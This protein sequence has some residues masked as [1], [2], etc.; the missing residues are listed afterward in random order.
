M[1]NEYKKSLIDYVTGLLNI[2]QQNPTEFDPN[3]LIGTNDIDYNAGPWSDVITALSGKNACIN[4]ILENEFSDI[5]ILYGGYQETSGTSKGFL[6]YVNEYDR[7]IKIRLLD[8]RGFLHLKFDESSNR[9]YGVVSNRAVYDSSGDNEAYFVYFNNLFLTVDDDVLP[10]QTYAYKIWNSDDDYFAVRDIVKHPENSWYLIFATNF[11][12]LSSPRV[13]ELQINVGEPNELKVW[14]IESVLQDTY[15]GYAFYG[16]YSGDTPHFKVII[17]NSNDYSFKLAINNGDNLNITNLN[18]DEAIEKPQTFFTKVD[19]ISIDENDIY[20]I[21]NASWEDNGTTKKQCVC[22]K[23][24]GTSIVT[25]YKTIIQ[26]Y[27]SEDNYPI[28]MMNIV[29]DFN[30]VYL[31]RYIWDNDIEVTFIHTVNITEYPIPIETDFI[32]LDRANTKVD[33]VNIYN[34][35]T[36]LRRNFNI[37]RFNSYAG[38][39]RENL[40]DPTKAVNGFSNQGGGIKQVIGYTGYPYSDYNVLVPRYANLY[41]LN[42]VCLF[43]RNFYNITRFE[44]ITTASVEVPASYLNNYPIS[45]EKMFGITNYNLTNNQVIFTKNK[46]E[47]LHINFINTINEIDEDT[48]TIYPLGAIKI[49]ENATSGGQTK[50]DNTKCTKYRINYNDNS[51]FIGTITWSNINLLN[52]K[53]N[54]TIYCDKEIDSIDLISNDETTIYLHIPVDFEIG[55]YYA[56]K[57]KVRIGDR[58]QPVDLQYNNENVLYNNEQ[59]QVIV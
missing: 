47:I 22:L 6:I 43:S 55:K 19:Y 53:T 16:W 54:F 34:E 32:E 29:R 12:S 33:K 23:Y 21:Y 35:R 39:F 8:T 50:Y 3:E 45:R 36:S 15:F 24:N 10:Q 5:F 25:I 13:Q 4:G 14:D 27:V 31:V 38:Y 7:P 9:V 58:P 18:I 42:F 28:P 20:F 51:T 26:D 48:D 46:Y 11:S 40:G 57:Q 41:Y 49:N 44:N 2:E 30:R 52:K 56:I 17:Q 59:V 1:T 37:L